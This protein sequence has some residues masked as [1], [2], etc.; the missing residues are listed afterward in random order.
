MWQCKLTIWIQEQS[1]KCPLIR[2]TTN[3]SIS[4]IKC[5]ST[6]HFDGDRTQWLDKL[7]P[8]FDQ[9]K[10]HYYKTINVISYIFL[11][12]MY[13]CKQLIIMLV[14]NVLVNTKS[15]TCH[16]SVYRCT[17]RRS[18]GTLLIEYTVASPDTLAKNVGSL[19]RQRSDS[20]TTVS[21][22]V[23][24]SN[25][26]YL[27]NTLSTQKT[28]DYICFTDS[29]GS[30]KTRFRRLQDHLIKRKCRKFRK[31]ATYARVIWLPTWR[32]W[33]P[34]PTGTCAAQMTRPSTRPCE[35]LD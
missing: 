14:F 24:Q 1:E 27:S 19:H 7:F 6:N 5:F 31:H 26:H 30:L 8:I 28:P 2:R 35:T 20:K 23:L 25:Y 11:R 32:S 10:Y 17:C 9:F 33:R 15:H 3:L 29:R 4:E 16:C 21:I 22:P 18:R 12:P 34:A 13:S